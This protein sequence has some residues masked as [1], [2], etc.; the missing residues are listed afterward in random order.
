[1]QY[2][3][4]LSVVVANAGSSVATT[5]VG[6]SVA[7]TSVGASVAAASA[8]GTVAASS[9]ATVARFESS[10]Q[11]QPED[12]AKSAG[13]VSNDRCIRIAGRRKATSKRKFT[14]LARKRLRACDLSLSQ[15]NR[16]TEEALVMKRSAVHQ[17]CKL[18]CIH[19]GE[20]AIVYLCCHSAQGQS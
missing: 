19:C 16:K 3:T 9:G 8:G 2:W 14:M 12:I 4:T 17:S 6:A 5:S 10:D 1:V 15:F 20:G 13:N 11:Q 7:A 18:T